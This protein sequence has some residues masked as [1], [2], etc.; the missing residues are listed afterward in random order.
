MKCGRSTDLRNPQLRV[1]WRCMQHEPQFLDTFSPCTIAA[2][3]SLPLFAVIV[4]NDMA[5]A[6]RA[7]Q[8]TERLAKQ[9]AGRMLQ[10][11]MPLSVGQLADKGR[12]DNAL[13]D[14]ASADMIV[15]SYNG[16]GEL[17]ETLRNWVDNYLNQKREGDSTVVALLSSNEENE[18]ASDSPRLRR[19]GRAVRAAGLEFFA[20]NDHL[21]VPEFTGLE[22]VG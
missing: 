8:A 7:A 9:F 1:V 15:V 20:P 2:A 19:M 18:D 12:F 13:S 16:P 21:E 6:L 14:A 10:R 17:P 22:V 3:Q 11:L 5:A 4:Y